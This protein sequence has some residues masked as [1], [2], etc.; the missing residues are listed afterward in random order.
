[1]LG[2]ALDACPDEVWADPET[3]PWVGFWYNAF[4]C[5]WFLDCYLSGN[6]PDFSSPEP[7]TESEKDPDGVLP[8]RTYTKAELLGYIAHCRA[9]CQQVIEDLTPERAVEPCPLGGGTMPFGELLLY[10]LRHVQ[11]HTG[12]LN[13]ILR[14]TTDDAPRWIARARPS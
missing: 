13:R 1:M 6:A 7:F 4:H 5:I 10:N 9:K 11:H 12:Q 14:D 8:P 3:D 2:A